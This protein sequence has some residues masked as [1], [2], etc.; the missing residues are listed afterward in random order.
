MVGQEATGGDPKP[1]HPSLMCWVLGWPFFLLRVSRDC[2]YFGFLW[3]PFKLTS[4]TTAV[5]SRAA[6]ASMRLVSG[7]LPSPAAKPIR[8][9]TEV[10]DRPPAADWSNQ[11]HERKV[12]YSALAAA[13]SITICLSVSVC[14]SF[15]LSLSR[16]ICMSPL[17]CHC[18][19]LEICLSLSLRPRA[20]LVWFT[21]I[22]VVSVI[23]FTPTR[24]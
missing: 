17:I 2:F 5:I 9:N 18:L 4:A 13:A 16:T 23:C 8:P 20:L 12:Q 6:A 1:A 22:L 19:S 11:E 10:L 15:G 21:L 14:L 7:V 3:L 24:M